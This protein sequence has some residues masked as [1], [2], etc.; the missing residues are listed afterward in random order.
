[1]LGQRRRR[2]SNA[3]TSLFQRVVFAGLMLA[4]LPYY[5]QD[6]LNQSWVNVGPSVTLAHIQ[7]GA[8]HDTVTQYWANVGSALQTVCQHWTSIGWTCRV[9]PP[10]HSHTETHRQHEQ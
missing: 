4:V 8:K 5:R 2:W 7:R 1:M 9:W 10:A 6:A 3:K